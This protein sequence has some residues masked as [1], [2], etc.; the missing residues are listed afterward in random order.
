[1]QFCCK[2]K[3]YSKIFEKY[4]IK[5]IQQQASHQRQSDT[6]EFPGSSVV[7]TWHFHCQVLA[8][9]PVRGNKI[10]KVMLHNQKKKKKIKITEHKTEIQ[11]KREKAQTEEIHKTYRK[12]RLKGITHC[13]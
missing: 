11:H 12:L 10:P 5:E 1:M 8:S 9:I 7:R 13:A 3:I 6:R 4:L 2:S